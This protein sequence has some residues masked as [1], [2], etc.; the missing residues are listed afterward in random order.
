MELR[1]LVVTPLWFIVLVIAGY[2]LRPRLTSADTRKYFMPALILRL[3]SAVAVGFLYQYYYAGGD[4]F[5]YHTQGSRLIWEAIVQSPSTGLKLF[6]DPRH[7]LTGETYEFASKI[8]FLN[9]PQSYAVIRAATLLDFLTFSTYSATA[10]LFGVISFAGAWLLFLGFLEL[11]PEAKARLAI[12]CLFIPSVIFWGSGILK[13]TLTFAC[14]GLATFHAIKLFLKLEF[15][16]SSLLWLAA[17]MWIIY[18]IKIYILLAYLP[19]VILWVFFYHF[20]SIR[21]VAVRIV[22]FPVVVVIALTVA[23]Y[24]MTSAGE[25]NPKY[26]LA[27]VGTTARV[28]AYDI[29]YW[30]GRAAGSGYSLGELD[31][32]IS[33]MLRLAPAAVNVALFRPYPWEVRN[34]L[35]AISMMESMA[36]LGL[37]LYVLLRTNFRIAHALTDPT[38][39]FCLFF[40]LTFSFAVGVSTYNFGTLVRYKIP[41]MPFL[42][43]ALLLVLDY[44]KRA[45]KFSVLDLTEK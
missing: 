32:S 19:A 11:Y 8:Y 15:R 34:P 22:S 38:G 12:A 23:Y 10:L 44:P 17:S 13:D 1:D 33:G 31:G 29:R 27:N 40:A 3:I 25:D 21:S 20:S 35:M 6:F 28:T 36:I 5:M 4:T 14:L 42:V 43:V 45:R 7:S 37:C 2:V 24:A 41:M 30:S 9:D 18:T 26:S 16:I 39:F